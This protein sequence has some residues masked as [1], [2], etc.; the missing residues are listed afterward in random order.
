MRVFR[1]FRPVVAAVAFA[2]VLAALAALSGCA[3]HQARGAAR[4]G[5][6]HAATVWP[7]VVDTPYAGPINLGRAG[8][9]AND[10]MTTNVIEGVTDSNGAFLLD[11]RNTTGL[12]ARGVV[13]EILWPETAKQEREADRGMLLFYFVFGTTEANIA[14][15]RSG[16]GALARYG[17]GNPEDRAHRWVAEKAV[18]P[19]AGVQL[20]MRF[21]SV[22]YRD[23]PAG[24]LTDENG[25]PTTQP[26]RSRSEYGPAD[27]RQVRIRVRW[28][29]GIK[30]EAR[31][32]QYPDQGWDVPL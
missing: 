9:L 16:S 13:V 7:V 8:N 2:L 14:E 18:M 3:S 15:E 22:E 12:M 6:N 23:F 17:D 24:A 10:D 4:D 28:L 11:I 31:G 32:Y 21:S 29:A 19:R 30:M 5:A 25:I 27:H 26:T 1:V 20:Y